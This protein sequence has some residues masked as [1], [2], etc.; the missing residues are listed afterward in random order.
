MQ[1]R[2]LICVITGE[3]G[4]GKSTLCARVASD[5]GAQGLTVA[6]LLTERCD[7]ADHISLRRVVDLRTGE[8]RHFGS[9]GR[10]R[11]RDARSEGMAGLPNTEL[12]PTSDSLTPGWRF[13]PGVFTWA[14]EALAR[15]T[16]C[17]LLV[18]DEIGPLELIGGRGWVGALAALLSRDY[19]LAL[20]VCRPCLL[21]ELKKR[22]GESPADIIEVTLETRDSLP[23]AIFERLTS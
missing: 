6:G 15:S 9:Q 8:S 19:D 14:N 21:G 18:L 17:N 1:P 5:A 20:V 13:D 2:S 10:E 23:H 3:R 16:P 7:T 4:S 22:L 11:D 12:G